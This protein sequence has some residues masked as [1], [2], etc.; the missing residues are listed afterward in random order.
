MRRQKP[1]FHP[2]K[3]PRFYLDENFFPACLPVLTR[4]DAKHAVVDF[5]YQGR[6]DKF[7]FNFAC[8]EQRILLTLDTDYLNDVKYKLPLTFG[9]IIISA[10]PPVT[11]E[12]VNKILLKLKSVLLLI[13]YDA[14]RGVKIFATLDGFKF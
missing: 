9:L 3:K 10:T 4:F 7:H 2:R 13:D 8:H 5:N 11:P 12:K 14:L 1:R 6:D